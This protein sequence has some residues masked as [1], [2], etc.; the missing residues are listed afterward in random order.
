MKLTAV[1]WHVR[2]YLYSSEVYTKVFRGKRTGMMYTAYPKWLKLCAFMHAHIH[3][4]IHPSYKHTFIC[5]QA[6]K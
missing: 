4:H 5:K 1:L 6:H 2:Q 3:K